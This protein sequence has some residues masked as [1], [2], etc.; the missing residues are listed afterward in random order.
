MHIQ[1]HSVL[2]CQ[3][4]LLRLSCINLWD[5]LVEPLTVEDAS[6][7]AIHIYIKSVLYYITVQCI[8]RC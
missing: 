5:H 2:C 7:A 6:L 4:V 8:S 1:C 3:R